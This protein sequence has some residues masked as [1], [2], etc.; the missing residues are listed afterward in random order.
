VTPRRIDLA[1]FLAPDGGEVW[2]AWRCPEGRWQITATRGRPRPGPWRRQVRAWEVAPGG[3][4]AR[5]DHEIGHL[6]RARTVVEDRRFARAPAAPARPIAIPRLLAVGVEVDVAGGAARVS[7]VRVSTGRLGA[8]RRRVV[9]LA[10]RETGGAPGELDLMEGIGE[11]RVAGGGETRQVAFVEAGALCAGRRP[12]WW[13]G[14]RLVGA[15][16]PRGGASAVL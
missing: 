3:A 8:L 4:E 7:L 13:D 5:L 15:R 12:A 11:I 1:P 2:C 10:A 6:V 9:T 14:V 16:L